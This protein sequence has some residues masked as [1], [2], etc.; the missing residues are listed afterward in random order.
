MGLSLLFVFLLHRF[1]FLK[2][3]GWAWSLKWQIFE[4]FSTI[5]N[6]SIFSESDRGARMVGFLGICTCLGT[7]FDFMAVDGVDGSSFGGKSIYFL[8][9]T[10][11]ENIA[12]PN[13]LLIRRSFVMDFW[14]RFWLWCFCWD[15]YVEVDH[16]VVWEIDWILRLIACKEF[17]SKFSEW[18]LLINDT[19]LLFKVVCLRFN[20]VYDV[21]KLFWSPF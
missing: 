1:S 20:S 16:L 15:L 13:T 2:I 9:F 7:H 17:L 3:N 12:E 19:L 5:L 8:F 14:K 11:D 4:N 6:R 18:F 10:F 21:F